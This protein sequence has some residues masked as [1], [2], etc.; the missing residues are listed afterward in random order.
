MAL[1]SPAQIRSKKEVAAALAQGFCPRK[2]PKS[3]RLAIAAG[4]GGPQSAGPVRGFANGRFDD[5]A[6]GAIA[7]LSA[8]L[9]ASKLS[10]PAVIQRHARQVP[11]QKMP[12][13]RQNLVLS[14][15]NRNDPQRGASPDAGR[16]HFGDGT[17][18]FHP[19]I[20]ERNARASRRACFLPMFVDGA[21]WRLLFKFESH[22]FCIHR[23][24]HDTTRIA[25]A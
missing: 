6:G 10:R 11:G 9:G 4:G 22:G 23:A 7:T 13:D 12:P 8:I 14:D 21:C 17:V 25:S 3:R 24:G 16:T 15:C 2:R 18:R 20:V 1:Q 19:P 5:H